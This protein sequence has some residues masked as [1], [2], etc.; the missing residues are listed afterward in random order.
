MT[1]G[2]PSLFSAFSFV[3]FAR[4]HFFLQDQWKSALQEML[5]Q[6]PVARGPDEEAARNTALLRIRECVAW[7]WKS[8]MEGLPRMSKQVFREQAEEIQEH[9]NGLKEIHGHDMPFAPVPSTILAQLE[10]TAA[11][12]ASGSAASERDSSSRTSS[13]QSET[14]GA[15]KFKFLSKD[16]TVWTVMQ[17]WNLCI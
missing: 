5:T 11:D 7:R 17:A 12:D 2:R 9:L 6:L 1:C 8:L 10:N 15:A 13:T 4:C 3:V 14:M 16:S